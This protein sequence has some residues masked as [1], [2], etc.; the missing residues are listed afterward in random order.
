MNWHAARAAGVSGQRKPERVKTA[1]GAT[2]DAV[3]YSLRRFN[4]IAI[5]DTRFHPGALAISDLP[6]FAPIGMDQAPAMIVGLDLL[7]D[8][9]FLIDY[10]AR[11]LLIER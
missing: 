5:G 10:P 8:R 3:A 1:G 2:R 6:V 4:S 7:G 9:R 11:R